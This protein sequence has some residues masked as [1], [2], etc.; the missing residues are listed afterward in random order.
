M[1]RQWLVTT[2]FQGFRR[3]TPVCAWSK[4]DSEIHRFFLVDM[5]LRKTFIPEFR[6]QRLFL[7]K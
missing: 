1:L 5:L 4:L 3:E 2:C 7:S 6:G